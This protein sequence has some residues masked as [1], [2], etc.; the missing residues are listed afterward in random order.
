LEDSARTS[1][2]TDFSNMP[3]AL[4]DHSRYEEQPVLAGGRILHD[5]LPVRWDAR[6]IHAQTLMASQ[7]MRH[8]LDASGVHRLQ[9][10]DQPENFVELRERPFG[11]C[12][13]DLDACEMRD[14][15]NGGGNSVAAIPDRRQPAAPRYLLTAAGR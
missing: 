3:G 12:V 11:F 9:L 13:A 4:L 6:Q 10:L 15:S 2:A 7:R 5:G 1:S 14:A 8:G